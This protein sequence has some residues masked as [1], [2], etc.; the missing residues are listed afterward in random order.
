M[1]RAPRAVAG[2]GSATSG[3]SCQR[4]TACIP[5]WEPRSVR[6][7]YVVGVLPGEG[8]GPDVIDGALIV[9]DAVAAAAGLHFDIR[10]GGAMGEGP[11]RRLTADGAEF[12]QSIFAAGGA[13]LCGPTG[14]RA[15]YDLRTRF[16]LFCKIVPIHP[17]PA[18]GDAAIVRSERLAGVDVLI[19]RE[20]VAG[21]YL[22]KFGRREAGRVAYQHFSYHA[23][24]VTRIVDVAARLAQTRRS[25]LSVVVKAGGVPEV[26][27]VWRQQTEAV[28][29]DHGV[30]VEVLD[31]DNAAFQGTE[32]WGRRRERRRDVPLAWS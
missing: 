25:R 18:L 10:R 5:G 11:S 32:T 21:L 9:L 15:V 1:S 31:I 23:D 2:K 14:G 4:L 22:G 30:A 8:I 24:Q 12:C 27:A 17:S 19:V 6:A 28:A 29:A 3:A 20:N 13:V 26:S 7:P 16:D